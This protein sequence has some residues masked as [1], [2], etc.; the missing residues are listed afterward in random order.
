VNK[1]IAYGAHVSAA[2]SGVAAVLYPY[3]GHAKWYLAFPV[4]AAVAAGLG[5]QG[6]KSA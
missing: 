2:V 6:N 1:V 4:V 5:I 3:Y